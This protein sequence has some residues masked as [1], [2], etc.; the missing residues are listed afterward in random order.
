M[1]QQ[2]IKLSFMSAVEIRSEINIFLDQVDESFLKVV[3]SM[4]NVYVKEKVEDPIIG[5]D[6]EGNPKHASV[7]KKIYDTEVKAAIEEEKFITLEEL[8]KESETW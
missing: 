6:I 5:Y 8:E 4:L 1:Y 3:H 7:M 2:P